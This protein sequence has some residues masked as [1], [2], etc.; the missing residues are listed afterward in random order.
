MA[1]IQGNSG[2]NFAGNW[3][4]QWADITEADT[5]SA[6][7]VPMGVERL[8]IQV[9]GDL[10]TSGAITM[11]GSNDGVNYGT[12][13]DPEGDNIVISTANVMWRLDHIPKYIRPTASAGTAVAMD[14]FVHGQVV[15]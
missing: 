11:Q 3:D 2:F 6:V 14:V 15:R 1:T 4:A 13:Q 5:G 8:V 10:T 7:E 12:L 9:N